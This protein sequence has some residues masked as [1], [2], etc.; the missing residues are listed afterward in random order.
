MSFQDL[1]GSTGI[2]ASGLSAERYRM[3]VLASNVANA[4]TTRTPGGGPYRRQDVVFESLLRDGLAGGGPNAPSGQGVR[5]VGVADD[6]T[7]FP[8]V[9]NPGHPDADG[10]GF[11][12][13]P[14]VSLPIEMVNLMT[15]SRAYEANLKVLQALR[16]QME[17]VLTLLRS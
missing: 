9:F 13:M 7:D 16:Q 6:P 12:L 14:N 3:E 5:V 8:R 1:L 2:S 15:A 4:F 11:V 17:Q 10:N